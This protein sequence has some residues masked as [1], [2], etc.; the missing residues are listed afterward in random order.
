MTALLLLSLVFLGSVAV[1]VGNWFVH[2][3]HLQT[4]VDAAALAGG[5]LLGLCFAQPADA[6]LGVGGIK[7]E[8]IRYSGAG[9]TDLIYPNTQVGERI[10]ARSR[11]GTRARRT[12][13][14][15]P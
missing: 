10:R 13:R 8:A 14:E 7:Q 1:D 3:R 9:A 5:G 11:C 6:Y 12:P 15:V 4:Q 2:K